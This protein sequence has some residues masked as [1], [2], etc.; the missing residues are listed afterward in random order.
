MHLIEKGA[1]ASIL[2]FAVA[3]ASAHAQTVPP[4]AP[5]SAPPQTIT[6]DEPS[7]E[8]VS[9]DPGAQGEAEAEGG[10]EII[11]TGSRI[12]RRNLDTGQPTLVLS[13][14]LARIAGTPMSPMRSTTCRRSACR[15]AAGSG[16]RRGRSDRVRASSTSSAWERTLTV[17]N[18]RRFVSSNTSSIFGPTG[19]GSQVDLN[20]IPTL[21]IDRVETI[22]VGGAPIYGSD[23]IAGT[24]NIITKQRFDGAQIDSQYG[25]S[26]AGDGRDFRVRGLIGKNFADGRGNITIAGEYS[27]EAGLTLA[28]RPGRRLNSTFGAP[29]EDS[30]FSNIYLSDR[31]IPAFSEFGVPVVT[32]SVY[33]D[34]GNLLLPGIALS[35]QFQAIYGGQPGVTDAAGNPLSF[36]INGNLVPIDFGSPTGSLTNAEGGNGFVLPGNLL[37]PV[38]RYLATALADS[39]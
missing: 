26:E 2:A 6:Q 24:I 12:P 35:P 39:T 36:D 16:R 9:Q 14:D 23:A 11:V 1:C 33:D 27:E 28:D 37:T 7:V 15:A 20:A 22:A 21:L 30:P 29:F 38:R 32:D 34:E 13:S 5:P 18:G 19:S 31:R 25:I 10:G 3:A 17:V 4:S 8:P